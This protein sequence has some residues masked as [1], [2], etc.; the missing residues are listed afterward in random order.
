[1]K[2]VLSILLAA[3][4][5]FGLTVN[6]FAV[7]LETPPQYPETSEGV[8]V[9][10]VDDEIQVI[11]NEGA[12]GDLNV[13]LGDASIKQENAVPGDWTD[14]P[15]TIINNS[16]K[17]YAYQDGS[18]LLGT[19][20]YTPESEYYDTVKAFDQLDV[21]LVDAGEDEFAGNNVRRSCNDAIAALD[22]DFGSGGV[23]AMRVALSDATIGSALRKAGYG[24][25]SMSDADVTVA[26]LGTY[27][28]DF[29]NEHYANYGGDQPVASLEDTTMAYMVNLFSCKNPSMGGQHNEMGAE[30]NPQVAALGYYYFYHHLLTVNDYPLAEYMDPDTEAWK[31][32]NQELSHTWSAANLQEGQTSVQMKGVL[33]GPDTCNCYQGTAFES[34][35][36]FT[37]TDTGSKTSYPGLEK[38]IQSGEELVDA[39]TVAAG[40]QVDFVLTSNVPEDLTNYLKPA[41]VNPP[42]VSTLSHNSP[43][44]GGTY[45]L[46]FEDRMDPQLIF[47]EDSLKVTV[48]GKD[49]PSNLYTLK[50]TVAEGQQTIISLTLDLVKLYDAEYF[51]QAE[52]GTAPIVLTYSAT[53]A[54]DITAGTYYN[55]AWVEYE[56]GETEKDIVQV[57]TFQLSV[58]KYDQETNAPLPGAEF[59]LYQKDAE[60]NVI[61]SSI[62]KLTSGSDGY[63][64][65]DGLDAGTYYLKETKAPEGYVASD[66]ELTVVISVKDTTDHVVSVQFANALIPHTGGSGTVV[67]T[68]V[69]IA[70]LAAAAVLFLISRKKKRA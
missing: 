64:I 46:T 22:I 3:L 26:Y 19:A 57:D 44:N 4:M 41:E 47:N 54:T 16:S 30:T 39:D 18:I 53:A 28:L 11:I 12:T 68:V 56:G 52:F 20:P 32:L 58:F 27:Y 61:E 42:E 31:T 69:G 45:L 21:Y 29:Y 7:Q 6:A 66:K 59:E 40:D 60:G 63:A 10:L 14:F 49:V 36:S 5:I 38:K 50:S 33:N 67:Y 70:I 15:I 37:L 23:S 35:C 9:V 48:N 55:T 8:D 62:I 13:N 51:T 17:N 1:M 43:L 2:K 24:S 34:N 65:R 25:E